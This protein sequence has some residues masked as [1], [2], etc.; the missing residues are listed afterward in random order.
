MPKQLLHEGRVFHLVPMVDAG[1]TVSPP[2]KNGVA[3]G[4]M[5]SYIYESGYPTTGAKGDGV[6]VDQEP[7]LYMHWSKG[8]GDG[9]GSPGDQ[10]YV[11]IEFAVTP[12]WLKRELAR[13]ENFKDGDVDTSGELERIYLHSHA[14]SWRDLNVV[15]K[16]ARSARD[17]A[18]GKPE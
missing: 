8:R 14:L 3:N 16:T 10:G 18:F 11:H 9:D 15:A 13:I 12:T 2:E 1:M 17:D 4:N 6:I 7:S 5:S